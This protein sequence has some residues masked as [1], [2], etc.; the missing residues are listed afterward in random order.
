MA[1][2]NAVGEA[3]KFWGVLPVLPGEELLA[4]ARQL[5]ELGLEGLFSIQVYGPPFIPLAAAGAA[6]GRIKIATGIAIAATRSPMETAMAAMDLDRISN[7][8]FILGLGSSAS[9]WTEGLFGTPPIKP[10]AHMRDT[11]A[12]VRYIIANAHQDIQPFDGEYFKADFQS[13]PPTAP[14]VREN[15]PIWVSALRE[16]M[17]RL[18]AEIGDGVIGHPVWSVE[19]ATGEMLDVLNDELEKRG[20]KRED[21]EVN[22]WP[23]VAVNDNER[24]AVDDARASIAF[25]ASVKNYEPF[26][27]AHGYLAEARACQAG[28]KANSDIATFMHNVP[29][30]M[31]RSFVACGPIDQVLERLEPLWTVCD[32]ICP[33]PPIW[34]LDEDKKAHYANGIFAYIQSQRE[35]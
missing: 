16:R 8:R 32:S 22:T 10:V 1:A 23:L 12:A 13:L 5:E 11:I 35:S 3:R 29:D 30:D 17:V 7:A 15:I 21:I 2:K 6:T 25:Y 28:I 19:W 14:P 27:Q 26:F 4:T 24:E 18:G 33:T 31:V 9:V 20:R 34:N